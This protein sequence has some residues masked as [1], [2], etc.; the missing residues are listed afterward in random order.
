MPPK[1]KVTNPDPAAAKQAKQKKRKFNVK[2]KL[3]PKPAAT[4]PS[5]LKIAD[6]SQSSPKKKKR[7]FAVKKPDAENPYITKEERR[8]IKDAE[9]RAEY[10]KYEAD[11]TFAAHILMPSSGERHAAE[12][13]RQYALEQQADRK[14]KEAADLQ[15]RR[16]ATR[17]REERDLYFRNLERSKRA[18]A[19]S[20]QAYA[21][22]QSEKRQRN[23]MTY[24]F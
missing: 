13:E 14:S 7:T 1:Y 19:G 18:K 21:I 8:Q 5:G 23:R 10:E 9:F 12:Q 22:E 4:A 3:P 15:K 24:G 20:R 6:Y 16:K 11:M 17:E 2:K